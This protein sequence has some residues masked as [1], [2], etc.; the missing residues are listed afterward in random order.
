[1][2]DIVNLKYF[3]ASMASTFL[4]LG[5]FCGFVIVEKNI[6]YFAFG[7]NIS[8]LTYNIDEDDISMQ[9][10]FM[11]KDITFNIS[12]FNRS[13]LKNINLNLFGY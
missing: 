1:M 6:R 2:K 10:H 11:G 4:V 3:L 13:N 12:N 8:F 9:F 7:E 5:L